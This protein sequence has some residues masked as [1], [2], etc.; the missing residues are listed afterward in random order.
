M[1]RTVKIGQG[2]KKDEVV[3]ELVFEAYCGAMPEY[4][5]IHIDGHPAIH[6]RIEG[7]V[8]GDYATIAMMLN[9]V[10]LV[11]GAGPGL[12]TLKDLPC[13][14]NTQNYWKI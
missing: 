9:M 1:V 14:R 11:L 2:I 12:L 4:D 8:M 6:Q 13:P 3:I 5:E 7:G 10:P